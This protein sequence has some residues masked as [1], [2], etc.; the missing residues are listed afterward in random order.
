MN[1]PSPA[2]RAWAQRLLAA[3]AAHHPASGTN[4][5]ELTRV[6]D[7]LRVSLTPFVGA[8]GF[9]VLLR[10]AL[11]LSRAEAP[12]LKT[13]KVTA[14]G[15]LERMEALPADAAHEREAA[16]AI[17]ANLLG[18]LVTFIGEPLTLRLT[19]KALPDAPDLIFE[20]EDAK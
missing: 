4:G 18:L 10:R 16:I 19:R 13:I 7:K 6:C 1:N 9:T 2:I 5:H 12:S 3:E 14:G 8:D 11:A 20:S 15:Q 17:T